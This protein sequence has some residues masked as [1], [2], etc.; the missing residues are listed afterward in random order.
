M[1]A[2]LIRGSIA[3]KYDDCVPPPEQP[4]ERPD[5]RQAQH[6]V[7]CFLVRYPARERA[8]SSGSLVGRLR[9]RLRLWLRLRLKVDWSNGSGSQWSGSGGG[10]GSSGF[11]LRLGWL[12]LLEAWQLL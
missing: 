8:G 6:A 10:G 3:P 1:L 9:L 4:T 5:A 11:R 2:A 7:L 12:A